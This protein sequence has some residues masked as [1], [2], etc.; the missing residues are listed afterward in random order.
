MGLKRLVP[1]FVRYTLV[2]G[3]LC[4][5][6]LLGGTAAVVSTNG[7]DVAAMLPNVALASAVVGIAVGSLSFAT[8]NS[9]TETIEAG[10]QGGFDVTDP[11]TF[12]AST[13]GLPR[14]FRLGA[15]CLGVGLFSALALV[16]VSSLG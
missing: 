1:L 13:T 16:G 15:L 5:A 3:A 2:G 14:R 11:S 10:V 9:G 6:L 8:N 4:T 7:G 12:R